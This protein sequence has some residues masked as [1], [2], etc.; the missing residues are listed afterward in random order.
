MRLAD[1]AVDVKHNLRLRL[2]RIHKVDPDTRQID[3]G[4]QIGLAA[5]PYWK[6]GPAERK[7]MIE[8]GHKL[9]LKRQAELLGLSRGTFYYSPCPASAADLAIMRRIDDCTWITRSRAAVCC[10]CSATNRL[11]TR[12][13]LRTTAWVVLPA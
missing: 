4:R 1:A 11:D 6:V 10:G 8:R 13:R 7:A 9:P 2:T 12:Q 3:Q 5:Q